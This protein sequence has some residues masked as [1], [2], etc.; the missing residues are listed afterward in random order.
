[1]VDSSSRGECSPKVLCPKSDAT[2]F[3]LPR[4][5]IV[6]PKVDISMIHLTHS[7]RGVPPTSPA[8]SPQERSNLLYGLIYRCNLLLDIWNLEVIWLIILFSGKKAI[9]VDMEL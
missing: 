1:M 9:Q 5:A 3:L 6:C 2:S 4:H 8:S 7:K